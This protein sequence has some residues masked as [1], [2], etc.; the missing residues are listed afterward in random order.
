[1]KYT[2]SDLREHFGFKNPPKNMNTPEDQV[3]EFISAELKRILPQRTENYTYFSVKETLD[4]NDLCTVLFNEKFAVY[5]S[6]YRNLDISYNLDVCDFLYANADLLYRNI[7]RNHISAI[8]EFR[9]VI[10]YTMSYINLP[11]KK[12]TIEQYFRPDQAPLNVFDV[13][14]METSTVPTI[15]I[16][17]KDQYGDISVDN[18][19][20]DVKSTLDI[21]NNYNDDFKKISSKIVEKLNEKK[22][23]LFPLHGK[24]GTG[25][26]EFCKHLISLVDR[27]FIFIPPAM[28][29]HLSSPEFADLLTTT[30]KGAAIV[31]EDAEKALMKRSGEDSFHNSELVSSILNLTDGI[32][33]DL[34]NI[35]VIATY[36]C[37]RNLVDPAL[38]RKGRMK[39]EYEFHPLCIE[40]SQKLMDSL[41]HKEIVEE[42]MTLADIFNFESQETNVVE[43][44]NERKIGFGA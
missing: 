4:T 25:K 5:P 27:K 8:F 10:V 30:Y 21:D 31:I 11:K 3:K 29:G 26:S 33:A 18:L 12:V 22:A 24:P 13:F 19:E 23:G 41:G 35:A 39:V 17:K 36:N 38:L 7:G 1:V 28:V 9:S 43:R 42:P 20:L 15:G 16:L 6:S 2:I 44:E 14:E 34:T 40:K 37:D 32:F